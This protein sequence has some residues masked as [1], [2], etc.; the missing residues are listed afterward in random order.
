MVSEKT[1]ECYEKAKDIIAQCSTKNGLYA[2]AGKDGYNAVWSRD[3]MI[4]MIG[5]SIIDDKKYNKKFQDVFKNSIR[6]LAENQSEVGQ[7][8]NAVDKWAPDRKPHVDFK[9]IDSTLWFIIGN[10]VYQRRYKDSSLMRKYKKNIE[11]A[12]QW[13]ACQDSGETGSLTQLPTSDWQDAFPHRYGD[14][15]N[16]QALYH[17]VLLL[18]GMKNEAKKLKKLINEHPEDGLWDKKNGYYYSFRWKNH[19]KYKEISDWFDTLGNL[20]AILYGLA[21]EKRIKGILN[22]IKKNKLADPYPIPPI[23]PPITKKSK[24]WKDYYLDCDAGTPGDYI[25]GGIWG[26]IGGFY[27]LVL[28]KMKKFKLAEEMLERLAEKNLNGNFPEWTHAKTK[29]HVGKLQG[30]EA[31]MYI[32]AYESLKKKRVLL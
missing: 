22:Y 24:H 2:S 7:I 27:T 1:K 32:L 31:G 8:P 11:K 10:H 16:T 15:I 5:A 6:V 20:L 12:Y 3:S 17:K 14:T 9:T 21:D 19:G 23:H 4:S 18:G 26:Y 25:N 29:E 30:W 28:I 13:L